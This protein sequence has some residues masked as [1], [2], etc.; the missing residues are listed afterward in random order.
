MMPLR[1]RFV[2]AF[3][4][5]TVAPTILRAADQPKPFELVDGDRV[6]MVGN[7]F[8]ERDQKYGYLETLLTSRYP[9]RNI[10]FRNVGWSGDTVFS[11]VRSGS[12]PQKGVE[13]LVALVL[14]LKPTV[15]ILGYGMNESFEGDAGLTKFVQGYNAILDAL[16]PSKARLVLLSPIRHEDLGRPLPDPAAH[17][18]VL[19][20]YSNAIGD[21]AAARGA[22]FVNL[23][24]GLESDRIEKTPLTDNGIHLNAYGYSRAAMAIGKSLGVL[25]ESWRVTFDVDHQAV[26]SI[27]GAVA[28]ESNPAKVAAR[29]K[30]LDKTLPGPILPPGVSSV[31][32]VR[33][34]R[35]SGGERKLSGNYALFS[36]SQRVANGSAADWER[37]VIITKGPEYEQ[38]EK[39]RQAINA[40]NV[41][42]FDQY[43]PQND[44][45]I[46]FG[47]KSEQG[48]NAVEIPRFDKFI[49]EKEAEI[50]KLRVPAAHVYTLEMKNN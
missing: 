11:Q 24:T 29:F 32:M 43:R 21:I 26:G 33:I 9:D 8:I 46:F 2:V 13:A 6:V 7:A 47:R 48:R 35:F 39:L 44:M 34:I 16:G 5:A 42:F 38:V 1:L 20:L 19:E 31:E 27:S 49:A 45:Y 41:L 23:F 17:N 10:I 50:A 30:I 15:I 3:F 22:W 36:D 25:P 12:G 4:L 28:L 18:R 40:K 37:G 14:E